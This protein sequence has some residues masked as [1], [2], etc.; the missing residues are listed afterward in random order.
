MGPNDSD[1]ETQAPHTTDECATRRSSHVRGL[2]TTGS[3]SAHIHT[4]QRN[5]S[6]MTNQTALDKTFAGKHIARAHESLASVSFSHT[7]VRRSKD[8]QAPCDL[9]LRA[10]HCSVHSRQRDEGPESTEQTRIG[11]PFEQAS[12]EPVQSKPQLPEDPNRFSCRRLTVDVRNPEANSCMTCRA[13]AVRQSS[14]GDILEQASSEPVQSKL[15]L[16]AI[17]EVKTKELKAEDSG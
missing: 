11:P 1:L 14:A 15:Q 4:Q 16:P 10:R 6:H 5:H 13:L 2:T 3:R 8:A 17:L 7:I 12:S 9:S